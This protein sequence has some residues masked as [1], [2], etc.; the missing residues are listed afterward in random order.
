MKKIFNLTKED[1]LVINGIDH[2]LNREY[3]KKL[4]R[5]G[6]VPIREFIGFDGESIRMSC[7][8]IN[9]ELKSHGDNTYSIHR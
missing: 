2:K 6:R 9:F 8:T 4:P 1:V 5:I 3:M 7:F